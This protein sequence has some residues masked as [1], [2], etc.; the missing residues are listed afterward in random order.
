MSATSAQI[1]E[2]EN[3]GIRA[4][5]GLWGSPVDFAITTTPNLYRP[6][7][8]ALDFELPVNTEVPASSLFTFTDDDTN[9]IKLLRFYDTG[10]LPTGGYFTVN[11]VVQAP[12]TWF[13]VTIDQLPTVVYHTAT[14][15]DFE[16]FRVKAFDGK[17]W[18]VNTSAKIESV[19]IP[20][21]T[22]PPVV[23]TKEL[24]LNALDLLIA[25]GPG[26]SMKSWQVIDLNDH[27]RS[28][29]FYLGNASTGTPLDALE[30][31]TL[32]TCSSIS[33]TSAAARK[34]AAANSIR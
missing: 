14:Q 29:R 11:G 32:T 17:Y 4:F 27:P 18:S 28:G 5:D 21:P 19:S 12:L 22:S 16:R 33:S 31:H 1:G 13:E 7:V 6:V 2:S 20:K 10:I 9:T 8:V 15:F 23:S 26:P 24:V 3:V 34:I 30:V 25:P